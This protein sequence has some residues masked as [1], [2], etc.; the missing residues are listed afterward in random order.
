MKTLNMTIALLTAMFFMSASAMAQSAEMMNKA[1][2]NMVKA[3]NTNDFSYVEAAT[4]KD[5]VRNTNGVREGSNQSDYKAMM[6]MF[7]TAFPDLQLVAED[8]EIKGANM[9]LS[10]KLTGTNTGT[11]NGNPPTGKKIEIVGHERVMFNK[12]GKAIQED[13]YTDNLTM[14]MQLG[15]EL[16]PPQAMEQAMKKATEDYLVAWST[17][18]FNL[19]K[20]ITSSDLIRNANGE[21]TSSNQT[22]I[23]ET[24]KFWHTAIPDFNIEQG[25]IIIKDGKSYANWTSTGT[26]T[27]MFGEAAPTGKSSTT[28]GF[29][30]LTFNGDGK[31][32]HEQAY[33]DLL[34]TVNAWGYSVT[35]PSAGSNK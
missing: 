28:Q 19:M 26:N 22:E 20:S 11:L 3:W 8:I 13:V 35:P 1:A 27:G 10:W 9:Y 33:Y 21:I 24:M 14:F 29:T 4:V 23:G 32:I 18:D 6:K 7:H 34:S 31:I 17:N 25:T 12:D 2:D 15:Y 16:S 30:V 5:F